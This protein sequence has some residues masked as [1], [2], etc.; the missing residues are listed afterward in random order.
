MT[1]EKNS[2]SSTVDNTIKQSIQYHRYLSLCDDVQLDQNH[3]NST[4]RLRVTQIGLQHLINSELK[5]K[6]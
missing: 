1:T 5:R 6:T 3:R 2:K 4:F